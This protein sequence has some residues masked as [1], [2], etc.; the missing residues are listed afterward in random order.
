[1]DRMVVIRSIQKCRFIQILVESVV[2]LRDDE[3]WMEQSTDL[4]PLRNTDYD[5]DST[6]TPIDCTPQDSSV[7]WTL[8][9]LGEWFEMQQ[10]Y[11]AAILSYQYS[12]HC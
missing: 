6:G 12:V 4:D 8:N 10:E 1:M 11:R 3:E 9:K 2:I 7:L 5:N